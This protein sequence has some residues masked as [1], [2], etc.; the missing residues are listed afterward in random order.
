MKISFIGSGSVASNTAFACGLNGIC[1]EMVMLDIFEDFAKGKAIDLEQAFIL[2]GKKD[3]KV[4][5]TSNYEL[6]RDSDAIVITAGKANKSG[7]SDREK[8]LA[9]NK[10]I[11]EQVANSLKAVIPTDDKQ[12]LVIVVTN[13]LDV[14]LKHLIEVGGFNKKKT[15]G[16]GNLLD[17]GRFKFYLSRDLGCKAS[18]IETITVGQ[19]GAKMVYL[20][21]HTTIDGIKYEEY[22]KNNNVSSA[23]TQKI[24][25][26]ST[27]GSN[28][29]IA[30][31]QREGTIFGPAVSIYNLLNIYLTNK[32]Q[33]VPISVYLNGEFGLK[34]TCVGVPAV[35]TGRGVEKVEE[36]SMTAEEKKLF[37]EAVDFINSL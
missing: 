34:N 22:A 2:N 10:G 7:F 6:V 25:D 14:I 13:P 27:A 26:D 8:L 1:D 36:W 31:L 23:T 9:D 11:I 19:H 37:N 4:V 15:I 30:L 16:S 18:N 24:C 29:I 21:S 32:S 12:P 3:I 33:T 35:L 28:E 17:T 20:L 5:G